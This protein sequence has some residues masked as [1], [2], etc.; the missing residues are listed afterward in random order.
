MLTIRVWKKGPSVRTFY[1]GVKRLQKQNNIQGRYVGGA[2][3][4]VLAYTVGY[5]ASG[6]T[7][8]TRGTE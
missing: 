5:L 4:A 2:G 1:F 3:V 8:I 7:P 6:R